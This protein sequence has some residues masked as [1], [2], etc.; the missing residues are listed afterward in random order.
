MSEGSGEIQMSY[1][2]MNRSWGCSMQLGDHS[3]YCSTYLKVAGK[4]HLG[5]S[6]HKEKKFFCNFLQNQPYCGNHFTTYTCVKSLC[7]TPETNIMYVDYTS[8]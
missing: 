6:H 7:C 2:E 8:I 3:Q 4:V 1:G 5:G